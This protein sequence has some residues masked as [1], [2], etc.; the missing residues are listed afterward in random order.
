MILISRDTSGLTR[1]QGYC[2]S[3]GYISRFRK[4]NQFPLGMEAER[5]MDG[6]TPVM[7]ISCHYSG[8]F[9]TPETALTLDSC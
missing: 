9:Q 8:I 7:I 2:P 4:Q 6:V 1:K 5:T 3:S